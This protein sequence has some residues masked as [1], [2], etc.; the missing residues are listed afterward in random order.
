[1]V[2]FLTVFVR[3]VNAEDTLFTLTDFHCLNFHGTVGGDGHFVL[4]HHFSG[5][6]IGDFVGD[7]HRTVKIVDTV[8]T[9]IP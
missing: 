9:D 1:M 5:D 7:F 6:E 2:L 3:E 8:E 4:H